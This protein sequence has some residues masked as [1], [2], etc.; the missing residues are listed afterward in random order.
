VVQNSGGYSTGFTI[1]QSVTIDAAEFNA[2]VIA[3]N[4][5]PSNLCMINA[6]PT[7]R[8]VLRGIGFHGGAPSIGEDAIAVSQGG[9]LYVEHCSITDSPF[10]GIEM[11]NGGNL[12]VTGI[13]ARQ[14]AIGVLSSAGSR[15]SGESVGHGAFGFLAARLRSGRRDDDTT[16]AFYDS[17][18]RNCFSRPG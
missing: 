5:S 11:L 2:S 9:S 8:V 1:T 10:S 12:F 17:S 6:G 16:S 15:G 4:T 13:D 14:C 7:D 18:E 3:T